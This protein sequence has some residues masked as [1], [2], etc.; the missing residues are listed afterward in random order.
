MKL[1]LLI[2]VFIIASCSDKNSESKLISVPCDTALPEGS[3]F[4]YNKNTHE[5]VI[6]TGFSSWYGGFPL[7]RAKRFK[8]TCQAKQE[9]FALLYK[10]QQDWIASKSQREKDSIDQAFEPVNTITLYDREYFLQKRIDD[11]YIDTSIWVSWDSVINED[12]IFHW[13]RK[14]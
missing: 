7:K 8:D 3:S 14:N 4:W 2:A 13:Y 1:L 6:R 9:Y 10:Q 11:F 12:T 5:Y